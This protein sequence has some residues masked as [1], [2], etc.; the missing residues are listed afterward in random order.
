[1]SL[2]GTGP[3]DASV[4]YAAS[5]VP[6]PGGQSFSPVRFLRAR[7]HP[8]YT[9]ISPFIGLRGVALTACSQAT[10]TKAR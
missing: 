9:D 7:P 1:M 2:I 5:R 10:F 3:A 4:P 8:R 6:L